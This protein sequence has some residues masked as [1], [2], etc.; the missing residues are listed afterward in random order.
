[1]ATEASVKKQEFTKFDKHNFCNQILKSDNKIRSA[2][3]VNIN[4]AVDVLIHREGHIPLLSDGESTPALT[5]ATFRLLSRKLHESKI[6]KTIYSLSV[7]EYI[8][9]ISIPLGDDLALLLS[10]DRKSNYSDI[11]FKKVKPIL[12][13]HD[14]DIAK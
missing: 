10:V 8:A 2:A 13:R 3:L 11:I 14:F 7:H 4:G 9:R 12:E 5:Q 1:M 6:G